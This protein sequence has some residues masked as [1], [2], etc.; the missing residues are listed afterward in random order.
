MDSQP[1]TVTHYA[2]LIGIDDYPDSPLKG[3]VRDVQE[4][5][6]QLESTLHNAIRIQMITAARTDGEPSE[7]AA[8]PSLWPT[9]D[10]VVQA[11]EQSTS[12]ARAGDFV[13]IHF[14]GHGTRK[15][16]SGEFSNT[17]TGDVALALLTG[18]E[19]TQVTY[20]WGFDLARL[21]K[22]MVDKGL[23]VTVVLD[24]CF[25][26]SVYRD[27]EEGAGTRFLPFDDK[28]G[29]RDLHRSQNNLLAGEGS[30]YR[31]ASS[32]P[33]WLLNPDRY[34]IL[35]AC[36]PHEV[37]R[38]PEIDGYRRG[39]MSYFL[40]EAIKSFGLTKRHRDIHQNLCMKMREYGSRRQNPLLYGN[41]KQGFFG[42]A[43]EDYTAVSIP[44]LMREDNT[45]ELLAGQAHG[46]YDG[47]KFIL[48]ALHPAV[49]GPHPQQPLVVFRVIRTR[50]LTSDLELPKLPLVRDRIGWVAHPASRLALQR[51]PIRLPPSIPNREDWIT[52]LKAR[53]LD[54][55]ADNAPFAFEVELSNGDVCRVLRASGEEAVKLPQEQTNVGEA[56]DILEHLA[57]FQL[58][59][60]LCNETV[61]DSFIDSYEVCIENSGK[62]YTPTDW[63]QVKHGTSAEM[64]VNNRGS[65]VL[66]VFVYNLGPSWQVENVLR[67]T[68]RAVEPRN[69]TAR[70]TGIWS[71]KLRMR[72]PDK[73]KAQGHRW[74]DDIIKIIVTS[75]PTS[76]DM[77]ELARLGEPV[78]ASKPHRIDQLGEVAEEWAAMG[79]HI[80]TSL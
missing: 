75:Q 50:A 24:C 15:P 41:G 16:P 32:L 43:S 5:K 48:Q 49:T 60:S 17:P 76:F 59:S 62:R 56:A 63:L 34:A 18:G 6:E 12:L 7:L 69:D 36:G 71:L 78:K 64:V 79:F 72:V 27:D 58:V 19:Q 29:M 30:A 46:I 33:N 54:V 37:A 28:I 25:S 80:R 11:F 20:L 40:L 31:D 42:R 57:R 35:T 51:F 70:S 1:Q 21:L 13:Y 73:M 8:A 67:G 3:C 45:L 61:A 10:N 55:A 14:S 68:Y 2:I 23:V 22:G 65:N 26:G 9:Y 53:S 77:L 44:V 74:C 38:E 52:A 4:L 47:D 39:F 66:Y